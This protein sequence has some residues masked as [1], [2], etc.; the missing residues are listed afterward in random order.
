MVFTQP[1]ILFEQEIQERIPADP[2]EAELL[3][4]A[5]AVAK[6]DD[7][8]DSDTSDDDGE[9]A[10][11]KLFYVYQM[12]SN[13]FNIEKRTRQSV[14]FCKP[15][16]PDRNPGSSPKIKLAR[17]TRYMFHSYLLFTF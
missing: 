16:D 6:A 2:F 1:V 14:R 17:D 7:E 8:S 13:F 5:E 3:R 12:L 4:M 10:G 11:E 9:A 15:T